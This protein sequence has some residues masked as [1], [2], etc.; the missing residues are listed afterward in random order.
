MRNK[1]WWVAIFDAPM[2]ESEIT[3][4]YLGSWDRN[5]ISLG[6]VVHRYGIRDLIN[7]SPRALL[8]WA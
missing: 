6:Y 2:S 5:L 4:Q 7:I 1:F 3:G 8:I